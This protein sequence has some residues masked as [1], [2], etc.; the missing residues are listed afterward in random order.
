MR[1]SAIL[2]VLLL[3]LL[4]GGCETESALPANVTTAP[5]S[6]TL[7]LNK[8]WLFTRSPAN[9]AT[10]FADSVSTALEPTSA[11]STLAWTPV[12]LPHT[13][14]IEPQVVNA[15]WQGIAWYKKQLL[16]PQA[17]SG[18]RILLRF[19][20]AMN[21]ADVWLNGTKVG[22]HSGGYLP[23]TLDIT[24]ALNAPANELIVR[25]DNQDNPLTGP[26]PLNTLDFNTYGGLYRGVSLMVKD[27]LMI[28]DEMLANDVGGGG[29]FVTYPQVTKE[30]STVEVKTQVGNFAA[31]PKDFTLEQT[32]LW[33][34]QKVAVVTSAQ[35]LQAGQSV[36]VVQ[37]LNVDDARLWSPA[38][39]NLYTL[40]TRLLSRDQV[41]DQ[42]ERNIGIRRFS[43]NPQHELLINGEKTFLRGVNRHQ[44]YPH[45]G[46]AV[47]AEADYRDAVKI[48]SAGFDYVRLSHYPHSTAFMQAAD[49][50]GLVLLDAVLGWQYYNP[51]PAFEQHIIDSCANLIRRDRNHPSVLAWECS[52]NESDMPDAFIGALHNTVHQEFPGAYSAGWEY[53]YDIYV[54]ARQHRLQHYETPAQPYIVSE[55]GDWEYY[56]QNAGFNQGAWADLKDEERTSRQLLNSGEKRLLQQA[57]NLQEA[58]ND[59]F[60]VPAFADGYW[61]M[62]DYNRGYADDLEA[63][64]IMS[65]YRQPKYA[66]YLFQSQRSADEKSAAFSSGPMVF[67]ASEWQPDS[68]TQVRVFSNADEVALYLNDELIAKKAVSRDAMSQHLAHPP[69][70]FD[71]PAY[72]PGTLRAV[73]YIQ[74]E[75]VAT[76]SVSTA[77]TPHALQ[78]VLD[79][80]GVAPAVGVNDSVF[81]YASV[82]DARG[83][84]TSVN[85]MPLAL[86]A[87]GDIKVINPGPVVTSNGQGAW[88]VQIGD[89]LEG[90]TL[91]VGGEGLVPA[92]LT[93]K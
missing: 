48:K 34:G 77:G 65:L 40:Q 57:L 8:D 60:T 56:A 30:R 29:V 90:A 84:P 18:K 16:R 24:D 80:S 32:L 28:T 93:L 63:S 70:H 20:A 52:L 74:G 58:H 81:V 45:V 38:T 5:V 19:E 43:F 59:N 64:G 26:K 25:L 61:V 4:L 41:L 92:T 83:N 35:H 36:D 9:T 10:D 69:F 3:P 87:T 72:K 67:I 6:Q 62:F 86:T 73:A 31:A 39:P 46:Y 76:H 33:Q 51:N 12:S 2:F 23:F 55:Y 42:Q 88:L 85:D 13:P 11:M 7:N 49:E 66:Y 82:V 47:S 44:E 50:L 14:V 1:Y 78:L 53:G 89:S 27:P 75:Q 15:Q 91:T 17:W 21:V 37:Q 54:Q 79:D 22:H 68:A 71:V